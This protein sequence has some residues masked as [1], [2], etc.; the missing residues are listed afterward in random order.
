MREAAEGE[1]GEEMMERVRTY[2]KLLAET[3]VDEVEVRE[4]PTVLFRVNDNTWI[5][6]I[7]RYLV[8]PRRA[9][10]VKSRLVKKM[11]DE[12]NAEPGKVMFPKG[13]SR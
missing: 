12:L 1:V 7:V 13:D 4:H 8:E 6:A 9:G 3:P 10:Q 11:L 2:R 5:D